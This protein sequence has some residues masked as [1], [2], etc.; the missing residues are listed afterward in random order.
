MLRIVLLTPC[1]RFISNRVGLGYQVPLGLV[2]LAG[3]LLDAG[4]QVRLIDNDVRG[5]SDERVADEVEREGADVV[6][7]GHSASLAA[8]PVAMRTAAHL[9][10]R[11]PQVRLVYG[12][13]YPTFAA[14]QV[15]QDF[16]AVDVIVRGEG[17]QTVV[18]LA[19][20]LERGQDLGGV[21]GLTFRRGGV[22]ASTPLPPPL[23]D[24]DAYRLGWEVVDLDD[25]TLFG[26]RR[27]VGVQ[28]SRGCPHRCSYCAQW[29]FWRSYRHRSP[30][31]FVDELEALV[32]DRG[33]T[34]AWLADE[35]FAAD[36]EAARRVLELLAERKLGLA[37]NLQ[38]TAADVVRD[39]DL[40]PLYRRA[41]VQNIMMGIESTDD[42]VL[43]RVGKHNPLAVSTK[44]LEILRRHD[45]VSVANIIYGFEEE[46][47]SSL[48]RT[49]RRLLTLDSDIVLTCFLTPYFWTKDGHQTR[50]A[51]V[52]QPD[53]AR[54]THRNQVLRTRYLAPWALFLGVK[55]SEALFHLRPSGLARLV[56]GGTSAT[57]RLRRAYLASG[58]R[59]AAAEW[60]ELVA[61]TRFVRRGALRELPGAPA[62]AVSPVPRALMA[63]VA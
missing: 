57:R 46:R 28:F 52:I 19:Q 42:A 27:A 34:F 20:A 10:A 9:K 13:A 41:G 24:L 45:I 48:W 56:F 7:L 33:V 39:E 18:A 5:W 3:P 15:L 29:S 63:K 58:V 8:H 16:P 36:R 61:Q 1:R 38:M 11:L 12:G 6:L 51:D 30:E 55:L 22:V 2:A 44:A 59:A 47:P 21:P 60:W 26:H 32:R 49:F 4:H 14:A 25:Y 54:F 40:M 43:E 23:A 17:E 50:P 53:Q 31:R 37:L 35:N 62:P